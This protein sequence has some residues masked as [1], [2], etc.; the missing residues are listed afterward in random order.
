MKIHFGFFVLIFTLFFGNK[1]IAQSAAC[2]VEDNFGAVC[3][4]ATQTYP[5]VTGAS[6]SAHAANPGNNYGCLSSTPNP[7]WFYFKVDT[8]G[9]LKIKESNSNNRDVDGALW[10]PFD[11]VADVLS[12]CDSFS[13]PIACD[14]RSSSKFRLVYRLLRVRYMFYW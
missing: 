8:G 6:S 9:T 10:G 13:A 4:G 3:I 12:E 2:A 7:A 1:V 11:S 5:A 14:Y